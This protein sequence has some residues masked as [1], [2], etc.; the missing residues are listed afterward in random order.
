VH[1]MYLY[2]GKLARDS[3]S[4]C[5]RPWL[6]QQSWNLDCSCRLITLL[7]P[8]T[9]NPLFLPGG[10]DIAWRETA[11]PGRWPWTPSVPG[12]KS[13]LRS[14]TCDTRTFTRDT[15]CSSL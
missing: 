12:N 6:S 11:W 14:Y 3:P 2:Q 7:R 1:A 5:I 8:F 10:R 13:R 15:W 4:G 9:L